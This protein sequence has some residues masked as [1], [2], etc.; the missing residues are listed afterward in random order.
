MGTI[1][2]AYIRRGSQEP[3]TAVEVEVAG[4]RRPAVVSALPFADISRPSS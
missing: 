4:T 1:A 2:L 3:G